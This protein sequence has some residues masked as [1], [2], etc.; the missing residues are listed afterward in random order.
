MSVR[1]TTSLLSSFFVFAALGLSQSRNQ[2]QQPPSPRQTSSAETSSDSLPKALLR[3]QMALKQISE[4]IKAVDAGMVR[5]PGSSVSMASRIHQL[6]KNDD[7]AT[8]VRDF[9][10]ASEDRLWWELCLK[11]GRLYRNLAAEIFVTHKAPP[12]ETGQGV[13]PIQGDEFARAA[14]LF[15]LFRMIPELELQ[16]GML[17]SG[18]EALPTAEPAA[19]WEK[20]RQALR[21][22]DQLLL[23]KLFTFLAAAGESPSQFAVRVLS[24]AQ[25]T[26]PAA[27]ASIVESMATLS[28]VEDVWRLARV[29]GIN[30]DFLRALECQKRKM[31]D[32]PAG[33]ARAALLQGFSCRTSG[34]GSS[35]QAFTSS[36][37]RPAKSFEPSSKTALSESN[38]VSRSGNISRLPTEKELQE[39]QSQDSTAGTVPTA[40]GQP[41]SFGV[42]NTPVKRPKIPAWWIRCACPSDH[43]DAGIVFEGIRWHAPVLQCPNPELRRLEVK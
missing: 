42:S 36:S 37:S 7:P 11:S 39:L 25:K 15:F 26:S 14:Q 24:Q 22:D 35:V 41:P 33:G 12:P 28:P 9:L 10:L 17:Q 6:L 5:E 8:N 27:A 3:I 16:Y 29:P 19:R 38:E 20:L 13:E 4:D 32:D 31:H 23:E 21:H 30:P 1:I 43:P 34:D 18:T 2:T 40:P